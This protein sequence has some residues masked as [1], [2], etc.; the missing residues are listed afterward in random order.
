RILM[1]MRTVFLALYALA[2]TTVVLAGPST[3]QPAVY[4]KA[5]TEDLTLVVTKEV[6][7]RQAL[8]D[9]HEAEQLAATRPSKFKVTIPDQNRFRF[10]IRSKDGELRELWREHLGH[11]EGRRD[12][13]EVRVRGV[14]LA[15]DY[16]AVAYEAGPH[17]WLQVMSIY[18]GKTAEGQPFPPP[19]P[20]K[21]LEGGSGGPYLKSLQFEVVEKD[22]TLTLTVI[23]LGDMRVK[24]EAYQGEVGR[25]KFVLP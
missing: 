4:E 5:L 25:R 8:R 10:C 22:E 1:I 23:L 14:H 7:S 2:T 17:T 24:G 20:H 15:G 21:L 18:P 16:V 11:V 9:L 19:A 6:V 12:W 13:E 3:T